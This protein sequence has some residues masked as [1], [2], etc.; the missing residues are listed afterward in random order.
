VVEPA[1]LAAADDVVVADDPPEPGAGDS[2]SPA[3]AEPSHTATPKTTRI[4]RMLARPKCPVRPKTVFVGCVFA[5]MWCVLMP[6]RYKYHPWRWLIGFIAAV[7]VVLLAAFGIAVAKASSI[8]AYVIDRA[9][10]GLE[11]RT[12]R[13]ITVEGVHVRIFPHPR[14]EVSHFTVG[15][16]RDEPPLVDAAKMSGTVALWPLVRSLGRDVR[17]DHVE[18]DEPTIH[19]VRRANGTWSHAEVIDAFRS[20]PSAPS[21]SEGRP[22]TN[23]RHTEISGVDV[24]DGKVVVLD[25]S[26]GKAGA[27]RA[28]VAL[29]H[30]DLN[31]KNLFRDGTKLRID[32]A[33]GSTNAKRNVHADVA[34]TPTVK[35]HVALT[36]IPFAAFRG[37]LPEG[38]DAI[39]GQG[40]MTF[41]GDVGRSAEGV[42][43]LAGDARLAGLSLRGHPASGRFHLKGSLDPR[44]EAIAASID[45][46]DLE[47]AGTHVGG[48]AS[49][50]TAPPH[51]EFDLQ[52]D[53]LD[54]DAI[55]GGKPSEGAPPS[56]EP[57]P[58]AQGAEMPSDVRR[59]VAALKIA[60]R[61]RVGKVTRGALELDDLDAR[62][63]LEHG[64]FRLVDGTAGLYGGTLSLSGSSVDLRPPQPV[65]N[66]QAKLDGTD[67]GRST[68]QVAKARPLDGTLGGSLQLHGAGADWPNIRTTVTGRG[69]FA[70]RNATLATNLPARF[71]DA[72]VQTLQAL[73]VQPSALPKIDKTALGDLR[74]NVVVQEGWLRL[75]SPLE[76]KT[77]FGALHLDGRVG[78]DRALDLAGTVDLDPR[79]VQTLTGGKLVPRNA[80][81]IPVAVKGTANEPAF[82]VKMAPL[83]VAKAFAAA[84]AL[85]HDLGNVPRG[86]GGGPFPNLPRLPNLPHVPGLPAP[87]QDG[88][89]PAR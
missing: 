48:T 43:N 17:I 31:A 54:L 29:E 44:S 15:G 20:S 1:A 51:G 7:V 8:A 86:I 55:L 89:A 69:D 72:F 85:P 40:A 45:G 10:P 11:A 26:G 13:K 42:V 76:V 78:L 33:L 67:L 71:A 2:P 53:R 3:Q 46:L 63:E 79:W 22:T 16:G 9:L 68:E 73:E 18:L 12:G 5:C 60:G 41:A 28:T 4:V 84:G 50:G 70:V 57:S 25:R 36:S 39:V 38:V 88:G 14:A 62:G 61:V 21:A 30:I 80:V 23:E 64:T 58:A 52:G 37:F 87:S 74:A 56:A 65:W 6:S 66:L 81:P 34:L 32:A 75:A 27:G 59:R 47:G 77:P 35:G 19:L 49:F 82:Q 83:D 24:T